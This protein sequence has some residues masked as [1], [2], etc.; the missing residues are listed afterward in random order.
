M[1]L[2]RSRNTVK[3]AKRPRS[4][5]ASRV[6][7]SD[8]TGDSLVEIVI[9]VVILMIFA[10]F[11]IFLGRLGGS[12]NVVD[13]AAR[14]AAQ[15][16]VVQSSPSQAQAAALQAATQTFSGYNYECQDAQVS[17]DTSDFTPGGAVTVTVT[18]VSNTSDLTGFG[19]P[20]SKTV[21]AS[22][23]APIELYRALQ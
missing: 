23:T 10:T 18:C 19:F 16:A 12:A 9:C 2:K 13:S 17:A 1:Q 6:T 7:W 20:G 22:D 5:V 14:A 3:V 8:E 15:A 11:V 21:S 4:R